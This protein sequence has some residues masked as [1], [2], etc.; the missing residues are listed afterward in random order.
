MY[1]LITHYILK[2]FI[3]LLIH[4]I[5]LLIFI[6]IFIISGQIIFYIYLI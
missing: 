1:G 3:S 2:E 6:L 4:T 5:D